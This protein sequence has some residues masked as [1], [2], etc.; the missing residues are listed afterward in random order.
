MRKILFIA[1]LGLMTSLPSYG[2]VLISLILG[3]ELNTGKIEFGLDGGL[4]VSNLTG[5]GKASPLTSL[6]LGFYF[7]F[8]TKAEKWKV[9]TGVVV[10]SVMGSSELPVYDLGD[11]ALNDVFAEGEVERRISGFYVPAMAKYFLS[12]H[13]YAEA[14]PMFGLLYGAKDV[15]TNSTDD[16]EVTYSRKTNKSYHPL[17]AGLIGGVGYR[18][19][20]GYGMNLALRYYHGL[21]DIYIDDKSPDLFNRNLYVNVG[22]PIGVGKAQKKAAEKQGNL[23]ED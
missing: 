14:G 11:P 9:H 10:K 6:N 20:K 5:D 15:F 19:S 22:I 18:L 2:Q 7:D 8:K 23:P 12:P 3:D 21:T 1:T 13:F 17:E 4:S 16:D